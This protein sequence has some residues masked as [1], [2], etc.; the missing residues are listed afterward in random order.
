MFV[1]L[2]NFHDWASSC[3]PALAWGHCDAGRFEGLYDGYAR[4]LATELV[5]QRLL[6]RREFLHLA[7]QADAAE[8]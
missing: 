4:G 3:Q 1:A 5:G 6:G 7:C 8:L 2:W